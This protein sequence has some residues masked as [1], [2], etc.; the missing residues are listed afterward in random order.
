MIY[1]CI[2]TH[3]FFK[4]NVFHFEEWLVHHLDIGIKN[5]LLYEGSRNKIP[6]LNKDVKR[7]IKI[8][9]ESLSNTDIYNHYN[10][11]KTKFVKD[12]SI[13]HFVKSH[14]DF[15]KI[16]NELKDKDIEV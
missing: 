7:G 3:L 2:F 4:Q 8:N 15:F 10:K 14:Y 9:N 13:M 11:I 5:F 6:C 12:S 1:F 16:K